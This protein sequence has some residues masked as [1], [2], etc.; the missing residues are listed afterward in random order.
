MTDFLHAKTAQC[1]APGVLQTPP[2]LVTCMSPPSLPFSK[3][4]PCWVC[5][6]MLGQELGET[7]SP[8][9][10]GENSLLKP[11]LLKLSSNF[12][13]LWG[14]NWPKQHV[15]F[16]KLSAFDFPRA[17]DPSCDGR[18]GAMA[19]D[20]VS[21]ISPYHPCLCGAGPVLGVL[22]HQLQPCGVGKPLVCWREGTELM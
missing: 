2:L 1:Q 20:V 18:G 22:G 9:A 6:W 17:A 11:K 19:G 4:F 10:S 5:G 13:F 3:S 16:F 8:H 12:Y 15:F 14:R 7:N 21:A